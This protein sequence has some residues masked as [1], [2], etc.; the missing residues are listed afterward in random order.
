MK[1][2]YIDINEWRTE[3]TFYLVT[4]SSYNYKSSMKVQVFL[5]SWCKKSVLLYKSAEKGSDSPIYLSLLI[6]L[7]IFT[8][9]GISMQSCKHSN[10]TNFLN[11]SPIKPLHIQKHFTVYFWRPNHSLS[12]LT[13]TQF[14]AELLE[15]P[16]L[17]AESMP[18][19]GSREHELTHTLRLSVK[20]NQTKPWFCLMWF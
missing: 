11:I 2:S 13:A 18:F 1:T 19:H 5:S 6:S 15:R 9:K 4:T 7:Q 8:S 10:L 20:M 17:T 16:V 12:L 14:A 3:L